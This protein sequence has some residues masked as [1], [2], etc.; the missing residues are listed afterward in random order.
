MS[1]VSIRLSRPQ[2]LPEMRRLLRRSTRSFLTTGFEEIPEL[3]LQGATAI[4]VDPQTQK[5]RAFVSLQPED[6]SDAVPDQTPAMTTLQAAAISSAGPTGRVHFTKLFE[7]AAGRL[8]AFPHGHLCLTLTDQSWLQAALTETGFACHDAIRFYERRSRT[9]EAVPQP[10]LLRPAQESDLPRLA[11]LDA[12][13]FDPPW[14]MG[15]SELLRLRLDC[16][17]EVAAVDDEAVGYAALNLQTENFSRA[18][19]GVALQ[20]LLNSASFGKGSAHLVR[21]AVDPLVQNRGIGR[22]LLAASI[23][24]AHRQGLSHIFLNTQES[25]YRSQRLYESL[26]FRKRGH[27]VPVFVRRIQ[28]CPP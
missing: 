27:C 4:A 20:P 15:A 17:I 13:A 5:L 25:N 16:H 7:F 14:H 28:P 24:R 9:V 23:G 6:P 10:A 3:L 18:A 22:Q 12:A 19:E 1:S 8:P 21:L 2:D 11:R 26:H